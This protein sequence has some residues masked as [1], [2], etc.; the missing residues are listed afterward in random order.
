MVKAYDQATI[1]QRLTELPSWRL[2]DGKLRREFVFG[3]FVEAFGFM[4]RIAGIR[5]VWCGL[6][7]SRSRT[8]PNLWIPNGESQDEGD[9]T[10]IAVSFGN[11]DDMPGFLPLDNVKDILG[12]SFENLTGTAS[13]L[14]LASSFHITS[15]A[16]TDGT[17]SAS[18]SYA[19]KTT[20]LSSASTISFITVALPTSTTAGQVERTRPDPP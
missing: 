4:T 14:Q 19:S 8:L 5:A 10:H 16:A 15:S 9:V 2:E 1:A 7:K 12:M 3:N 11:S 17:V 6:R 20:Y 18:S 13:L